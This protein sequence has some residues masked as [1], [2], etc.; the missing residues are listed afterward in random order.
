VTAKLTEFE[1]ARS[2]VLASVRRLAPETVALGEALGR[3]L[4]EQVRSAGDVPPFDN[5]AMDGFAVRAADSGPGVRLRI[6]DHSRAGAPAAR[7]VG[8]GEACAISTGAAIPAGADAVVAVEQ[9]RRNEGEVELLAGVEAGRFVR[10]A[11]EDARAG[12]AL[13]GPGVSLGP[14]ELGVLASAGCPSVAVG[15]RPRVAIVTTGDELVGVEEPLRAGAVRNSA[16]FVMP[17]LVVRAGGEVASLAHAADDR[18]LIGAAIAAALGADAAVITGG[19]SVGE[20][21]HVAEAFESLAVA[22]RIAG[23]ALRPGKPFWF[24]TREQTLVFGLPGNPVSSLVTFVLFVTPALAAMAGASPQRTRTL[25][26][27]TTDREQAPGRVDA[28]RCRLALA[29]GGWQATPTGPQGSHVL[30]SMLGAD[31]LALI[32]GGTGVVKAGTQVTV[33]LL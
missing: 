11:G 4:A 22:R 1:Q 9:T 10:R 23:V 27:L 20:H 19:M 16:A 24:G 13:L 15:R 7:A 31:A 28:V 8:V 30:T 5:S 32:P 6:V 2:L 26:T 17:A 21:D 3:V 18:D 25:A 29:P 33:E 14:A 12:E